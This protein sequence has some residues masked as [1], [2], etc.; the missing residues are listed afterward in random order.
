MRDLYTFDE[1]DIEGESSIRIRLAKEED[2][3]EDTF[4]SI[5]EII[6]LQLKYGYSRADILLSNPALNEYLKGILTYP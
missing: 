6:D 5:R 1:I 2:P 4:A 3:D